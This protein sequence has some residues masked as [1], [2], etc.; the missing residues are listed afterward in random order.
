MA[1][2]LLPVAE[3]G[4]VVVVV[5]ILLDYF[6]F[7]DF[8]IILLHAALQQSPPP[9]APHSPHFL[10]LPARLLLCYLLDPLLQYLILR[11]FLLD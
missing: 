8:E 2:A 5:V 1:F 4:E 10:I 3:L 7:V 6:D 9:Y 11:K